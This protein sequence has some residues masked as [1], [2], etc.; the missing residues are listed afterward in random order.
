MQATGSYLHY[1]EQRD[2]MLYTPEMSRCA[3]AV[4]LWATLK[5]LGKEG[6]E[7]LVDRLCEHANRFGVE[8]KARRFRILNEV[9][10]NQV[11]VACDTP[12]I[13][14]VTLEN[15]QKSGECWCGG[16]VWNGEPVIRISVCSWATTTADVERTVSAFADARDKVVHPENH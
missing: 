8:L 13:T 11:L 6:L 9:V 4:E 1:S 5:S 7:Q 3:R 12:D 10:F 14:R 2:G 15:L 16:A